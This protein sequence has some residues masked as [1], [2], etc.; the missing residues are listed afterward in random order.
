VVRQAFEAGALTN[1]STAAQGQ[2]MMSKL[3]SFA[4]P[5]TQPS[6]S[7]CFSIFET[8]PQ[9][10]VNARRSE[11]FLTLTP[12]WKTIVACSEE[13]FCFLKSSRLMTFTGVPFMF[14]SDVEIKD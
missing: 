3:P 4:V 5:C 1:T 6:I 12:L 7:A 14:V 8:F 13:G 10:S 2:G 9:S 11:K